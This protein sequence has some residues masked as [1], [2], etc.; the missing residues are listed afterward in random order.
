MLELS[1]QTMFLFVVSTFGNG[2][3][4]NDA[5]SFYFELDNLF[6]RT[7]LDQGSSFL[8]G[9]RYAVCALGSSKY[10][11]FCAFGKNLDKSLHDL[12]A[13]QL[14][15]VNICDEFAQSEKSFHAWIEK[16]NGLNNSQTP[17]SSFLI[18]NDTQ[19]KIQVYKRIMNN[20]SEYFNGFRLSQ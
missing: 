14:I 19:E 16:I 11:D 4:P 12:G 17:S 13:H 5:R 20:S 10:S 15:E 9:L 2:D 18:Q 6:K 1:P 3:P 7:K 8:K